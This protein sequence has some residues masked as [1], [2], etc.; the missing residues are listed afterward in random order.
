MPDVPAKNC[1]V[2]HVALNPIT[3]PWSVMRELAL[4]QAASGLYAGVGFGIIH[5]AAW[6]SLYLDELH[7][8]QL[9]AFERTTPKLFGTASFLW[10]VFRR[11]GIESWV[12]AFRQ[13]TGAQRVVVHFH[14][15]WMSGVFL[16]L[17]TT[18]GA[19]TICVATIH[20]VNA[21]LDGKPLRR[22]AHRWM[23]RRLAHAP[24]HLTSVDTANLA[25]AESMFALPPARFT[26][27]ANGVPAASR[28]GC[29]FAHGAAEFTLG[30]VGSITER[31]G[32][33]LAA[34]AAVRAA[35]TG[36]R[37]R[38]LIAGIGD[39]SADATAY[40]TQHPAVVT[41]LGHRNNPRESIMPEL[42]LLAVMS[43]QEG[44]PM[45]IIEAQSA[46]VPVAATSVGGIPHAVRPGISGHLVERSVDALSHVICDLYDHRETLAALSTTTLAL[47]RKE[48]AID[49]VVRQYHTLY[50]QPNPLFPMSTAP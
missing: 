12:A 24:A 13:Q 9:P 5:D 28:P 48:F 2:L 18:T 42:D 37:V 31:K 29:P 44:L 33:R 15:A 35:S 26:V 32:W 1:A 21:Q 39:E 22:A 23:A 25:L 50:M 11:P 4:A 47:F 19:D 45:S 14:N 46:G 40:A 3:G 6:P 10:Q 43:V 34:E 17:H 20:G 36:R 8:T 49:H 30:H 38:V 16:P 7:N 41:Y 27:I